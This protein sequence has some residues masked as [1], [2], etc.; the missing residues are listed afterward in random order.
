MHTPIAAS[1]VD[2]APFVGRAAEEPIE[3]TDTV[4]PTL[5]TKCP[6]VERGVVP[7]RSELSLE[8]LSA[9]PPMQATAA[10]VPADKHS[11][12]AHPRRATSVDIDNASLTKADRRFPCP[13]C[14]EK[15]RSFGRPSALRI[16]MLTHT[17]EK[18]EW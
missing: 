7:A 3:S 13:L 10:A 6:E 17:G 14:R 4:N 11:S 12:T 5:L 1:A 18:R 16:H 9:P 8:V 15:P 2:D